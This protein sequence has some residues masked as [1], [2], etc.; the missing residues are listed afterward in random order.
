MNFCSDVDFY[1][2]CLTGLRTDMTRD[3]HSGFCLCLDCSTDL[4]TDSTMDC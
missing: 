4:M 2:D 1:L 3:S